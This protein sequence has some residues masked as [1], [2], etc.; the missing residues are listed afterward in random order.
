[1]KSWNSLDAWLWYSVRRELLDADLEELKDQMKGRV[2]EIGNGRV[3]R[4]GR[5]QPPVEE[6][7]AWI[8]LDLQCKMSPHIQADVENLPL[9]DAAFDTVVCLEVMEYVTRPPV[10]LNEMRRVLKRGG[11]LILATPFLHRTDTP[12][13]YWRFTEPSLRY[14]LQQ[15]GFDV[16][17]F[18]A[19]GGALAVAVNILK[20]AIHVQPDGWRR[21]WLGYL[22]RPLLSL[23][24]RLDGPSARR[25]PILAMFST[26]YMAVACVMDRPIQNNPHL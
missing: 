6:A 12:H 5:F 2:L 22:A 18:R 26:G 10:A 7:E 17:W 19:Q 8:Y 13:D 24:W 16:V 23:L 20:Y 25:Q 4:R 9:K 15:T 3:G 14:L 21:R 1:M 11:K